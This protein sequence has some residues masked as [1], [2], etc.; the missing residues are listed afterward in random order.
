MAMPQVHHRGAGDGS[1]VLVCLVL[2]GAWAASPLCFSQILF[3]G[4][5]FI[6]DLLVSAKSGA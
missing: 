5:L 1:L 3:S 2:C 6:C 4:A